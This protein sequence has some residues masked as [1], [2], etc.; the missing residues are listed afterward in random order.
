MVQIHRSV[1]IATALP[2]GTCSLSIFI[3]LLDLTNAHN[4]VLCVFVCWCLFFVL[5]ILSECCVL[6]DT[7]CHRRG[8]VWLFL[9]V[10]LCVCVFDRASV[11]GRIVLCVSIQCMLVCLLLCSVIGVTV[12]LCVC[13]TVSICPVFGVSIQSAL[14]TVWT[15]VCVYMFCPWSVS[16][17]CKCITFAVVFSNEF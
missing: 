13:V 8:V 1:G 2:S 3:S 11:S 15:F 12:W 9:F 10:Y 6:A 7:P 17:W 14:V 16:L 5:T 4:Y